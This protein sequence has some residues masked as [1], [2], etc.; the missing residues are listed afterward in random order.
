MHH[1]SVKIDKLTNSIANKTTGDIFSTEVIR[2][3]QR[4]KI[5]FSKW[6][7]DWKNEV[8]NN[9]VHKLVIEKNPDVIQGLISL[10]DKQYY[11]FIN[12]IESADFNIGKN[13]IYEGVAGNLFA[14]ACRLSLKKGYDGEVSFYSKTNLINH[15]KET[16]KAEQTGNSN[17]MIIKYSAALKLVN[18]YYEKK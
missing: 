9:E 2:I 6:N 7:F 10:T 12:L 14:F 8:K 13:K 11:V 15:Y 3:R 1:L 5:N 17:L 18:R 16:L 4:D